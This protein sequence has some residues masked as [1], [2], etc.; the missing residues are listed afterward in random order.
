MGIMD[1]ASG[2]NVPTHAFV[3]TFAAMDLEEV[4]DQA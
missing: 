1:S 4:G 3:N 2:A